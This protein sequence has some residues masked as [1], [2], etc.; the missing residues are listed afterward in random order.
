MGDDGD[1]T[2]TCIGCGLP[3]CEWLVTVNV[4]YTG[5]ITWTAIHEKCRTRHAD[6]RQLQHDKSMV[7]LSASAQ[8][9]ADQ[10]DAAVTALR[11]L[12]GMADAAEEDGFEPTEWV[13]KVI[14][15]M[16]SDARSALR[17]IEKP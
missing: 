11:P 1:A 17:A 3:A 14:L 6:A 9:I 15:G 10:R 4:P 8:Q 7:A 2:L 16:A 13:N 5:K 12:A